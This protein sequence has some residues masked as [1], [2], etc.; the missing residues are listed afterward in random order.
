[1]GTHRLRTFLFALLT[2]LVLAG[3]ASPAQ[4]QFGVAAGLN[5]ES[6]EDI[7]TSTDASENT[8][9]DNSTGYHVGVVYDLGLGPLSIRPG[10]FYRRVGQ[11]YDLP[12]SVSEANANVAAWEVPVDVRLALFS[13]SAISPYVLAGPKASFVRSDVQE[14]DDQLET[15]S[16]SI[17]LGVGV[18]ISLGSAFSLQPELRYDYGATKYI[19]E[20]IEVGNTTFSQKDPTLSAFSLRL[21]LVF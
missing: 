16:Y 19:D 14:I 17:A 15:V 18:G 2:G 6:V 11:T 5:F 3:T 20:E 9:L 21:N 13:S 10:V 1:M 12:S 4:A 7:D 8:T